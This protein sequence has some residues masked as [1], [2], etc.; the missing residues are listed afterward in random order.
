MYDHTKT[1]IAIIIVIMVV[2]IYSLI[3]ASK[4]ER[5]E[6]ESFALEHN[7]KPTAYMKGGMHLGF[8]NTIN[9]N[10]TTGTNMIMIT[11]PD[12]TCYTCDDGKQYWREN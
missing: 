4:K 9:A 6:W 5:K 1:T 2:L 3:V 12:K 10:G 11:E 8:G 7:C